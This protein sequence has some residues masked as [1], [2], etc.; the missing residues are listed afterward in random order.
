MYSFAFSTL[1]SATCL[2]EADWKGKGCAISKCTNGQGNWE[3]KKEKHCICTHRTTKQ[4]EHIP[5]HWGQ[6]CQHQSCPGYVVDGASD[7]DAILQDK[8]DKKDK[9]VIDEGSFCS[10]HGVCNGTTAQ[11][12]CTPGFTGQACATPV[13]L[14][15]DRRIQ[16]ELFHRATMLADVLIHTNPTSSVV[17]GKEIITW[18]MEVMTKSNVNVSA[19]IVHNI[20]QGTMRYMQWQEKKKKKKGGG[21]EGGGG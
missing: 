13:S 2:C 6:Y 20:R 17:L 19:A 10:H 5:E 3:G 1:C 21:G 16:T 14:V 18:E 8:K 15:T 11:C 7:G 4:G 12:A 9:K